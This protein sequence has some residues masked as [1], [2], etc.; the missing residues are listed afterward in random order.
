MPRIYA[1]KIF[2][3]ST[4]P[5]LF[6]LFMFVLDSQTEIRKKRKK[7]KDSLIAIMVQIIPTLVG[8]VSALYDYMF[9]KAGTINRLI[10]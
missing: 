9:N 2:F 1:R 7:K 4:S 6:L 5:C 3:V 10:C 8:S